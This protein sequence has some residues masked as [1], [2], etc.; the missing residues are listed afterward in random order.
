MLRGLTSVIT[1][2]AFVNYSAAAENESDGDG[3]SCFGQSR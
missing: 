3:I 1:E 2:L